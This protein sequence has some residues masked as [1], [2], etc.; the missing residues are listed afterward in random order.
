MTKK[1]DVR[2]ARAREAL[3]EE[4][5]RDLA[6]AQKIVE[7]GR[8]EIARSKRLSSV[9]TRAARRASGRDPAK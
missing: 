4:K 8:A 6:R 9:L 7:R 3:L 5:E 2:G 1:T